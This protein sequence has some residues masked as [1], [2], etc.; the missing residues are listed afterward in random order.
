MKYAAP[1]FTKR[2]SAET[3]KEAY[4]SLAK[5]VATNVVSNQD[6]I[7]ETFWNAAEDKDANLPTYKLTLF[8]MLDETERK[9]KFCN[10]C[11]TYHKSFFINQDYNC[12]KCNMISYVARLE[13]GLSIKKSYRKER[14]KFLMNKNK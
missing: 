2:F 3:K 13:E 4:M 14:L 12:S 11:K 5:W 8:C 6:E 1:F 9:N 7:G 10:I